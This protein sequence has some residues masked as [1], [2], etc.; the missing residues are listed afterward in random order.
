MNTCIFGLGMGFSTERHTGRIRSIIAS[1]SNKLIIILQQGFFK[2]LIAVI[3]VFIGFIIGALI[4]KVD[5][6]GV[7]ILFLVFTI[8]AAMLS[9]T[10]FGLLLS[11]LGLMTDSMHFILNF[12]T[13]VLMIFCGANFPIEQL[14]FFGRM[15]S[16][17]LPL[18][19]SI[20]AANLLFNNF[21]ANTFIRLISGEVLMFLVYC[22][23]AFIIVKITK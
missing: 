4:F 23:I 1:P 22:F 7:N 21:E 2:M 12:S 19:R 8:F 5:F 20:E 9:A 14:P 6:S 17:A 10:G 3:K 18:T 11:A 15:V 16:K 13:Y